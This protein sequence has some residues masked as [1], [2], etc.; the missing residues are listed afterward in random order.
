MTAIVE[1]LVPVPES[2][3]F[4]FRLRIRQWSDELRTVGRLKVSATASPTP[5]LLDESPDDTW[6]QNNGRILGLARKP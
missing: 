5:F 3:R 2:S 1:L 6:T 4:E